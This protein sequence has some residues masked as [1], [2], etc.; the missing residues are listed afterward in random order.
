MHVLASS[1]GGQ[2]HSDISHS[3]IFAV[4]LRSFFFFS[5]GSEGKTVDTLRC[6]TPESTAVCILTNAATCHEW[7]FPP[8]SSKQ[9]T[10]KCR[11]TNKGQLF[12]VCHWFH[13][14]TRRFISH[15]LPTVPDSLIDKQ[16]QKINKHNE[17]SIKLMTMVST[18]H[19]KCLALASSDTA[20]SISSLAR[21]LSPSLPQSFN[22]RKARVL[23]PDLALTHRI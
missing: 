5:E 7:I 13:C 3:K 11:R 14:R 18:D 17:G 8:L 21:A 15:E 23:I 19:H 9:T 20:R 16:S 2:S 4:F 12:L 10:Y 22:A 1:R 6:E